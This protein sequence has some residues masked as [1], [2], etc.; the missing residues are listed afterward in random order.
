MSYDPQV[1]TVTVNFPYVD[2]AER[3]I[4]SA[5]EQAFTSEPSWVTVDV[6]ENYR[7]PTDR[8]LDRLTYVLGD[9]DSGVGLYCK[10]C[11]HQGLPIAY[12]PGPVSSLWSDDPRVVGVETLTSLVK[13]GTEHLYRLHTA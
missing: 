4:Q 13:A 5:V 8:E 11:D 9:E 12:L 2:V 10:I 7:V 6:V 1:F 3:T